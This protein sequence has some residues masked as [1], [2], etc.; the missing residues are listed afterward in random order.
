MFQATAARLR[1]AESFK[2]RLLAALL[3][4]VAA[5]CAFAA[6]ATSLYMTPQARV[7]A[8]GIYSMFG[9]GAGFA[10]AVIRH[11]LDPRPSVQAGLG[12]LAGTSFPTADEPAAPISE[13]MRAPEATAPAAVVTADE[14]SE[15]AV[16]A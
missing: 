9:T 16:P 12:A 15:E 13:P 14:R 3:A 1:A 10:C 6:I 11:L 4:G 5:A 8:L 2:Q 7:V